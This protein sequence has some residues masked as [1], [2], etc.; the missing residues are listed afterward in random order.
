MELLEQEKYDVAFQ[1][2]LMN[3]EVQ[4][5]FV[6]QMIAHS[7]DNKVAWKK[8]LDYVRFLDVDV[9]SYPDLY[10][11]IKQGFLKNIKT[12]HW[13]L[14]EERLDGDPDYGILLKSFCKFYLKQEPDIAKSILYRNNLSKNLPYLNIPNPL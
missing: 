7:K 1:M 9:T 5:F 4:R 11:K 10:L 8:L 12:I 2:V 13:S 14:V 3:K 6:E